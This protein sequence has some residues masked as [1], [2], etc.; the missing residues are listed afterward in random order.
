MVWALRSTRHSP[1]RAH[2]HTS[3]RRDEHDDETGPVDIQTAYSKLLRVH[4]P[5]HGARR[6]RGSDCGRSQS[7]RASAGDSQAHHAYYTPA[8]QPRRLGM[9]CG[10]AGTPR[11]EVHARLYPRH[12][13]DWFLTMLQE[14]E[15]VTLYGNKPTRGVS[16]RYETYC[17]PRAIVLFRYECD[18]GATS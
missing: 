10:L 13:L 2:R 15:E 3:T 6:G 14:E 9:T 7:E 17:T 4:G 8:L 18:V 12:S 1:K 11:C 16:H 5:Q